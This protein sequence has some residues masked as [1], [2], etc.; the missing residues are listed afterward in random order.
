[1]DKQEFLDR[2]QQ[3]LLGEVP[4]RV[5][6]ENLSYYHGYIQDEVGKGRA[7]RQVLEELGDPRLIARTIIDSENSAG[8]RPNPDMGPGREAETVFTTYGPE[9]GRGYEGSQT[10]HSFDVTGRK[11]KIF[12]LVAL[13]VLVLV[14]MLV[15]WVIGGILALIGPLLPAIFLVW[16]VLWF[17]R[18]FR[19]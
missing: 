7:E 1:M 17:M 18:V 12:G 5:I 9:E 13:A 2:L 11:L 15:F 4:Q 3:A 10:F 8:G 19:R 6:Q 14:L 16:L